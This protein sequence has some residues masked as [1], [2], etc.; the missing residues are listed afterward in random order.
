M[1]L[2]IL[3]D[4][5]G[6]LPALE[7]VIADLKNHAPDQV[8]NLGDCA[9]GPLWP[10][11]SMALLHTLNWPT[12]RGNCDRAIG[13]GGKHKLSAS[14]QF[15]F[16]RLSGKDRA[17]LGALPQT[18]EITPEILA[19]HGTPA[20]D[21]VYLTELVQD[22]QLVPLK[23]DEIARRLGAAAPLTLC[24]HSHI[25][26]LIQVEGGRLILN[27]GSVGLPAYDARDAG[28]NLFVSESGSPHARYALV[29]AQANRFD[30]QHMA[31]GYNH[32]EAAE[33][34]QRENRPDWVRALL[35]GTMR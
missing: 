9:S 22:G 6:N 17:W 12:V 20:S 30:I 3:S 14:D 13:E 27:P 11:E 26:R 5:H 35:T 32:R 2:A 31:A 1:R 29:T 23:P 7:A 10:V 4:I 15:A 19:C 16:D 34:A 8:I 33:K 24:G 18:I 25:T 28:G 21:L